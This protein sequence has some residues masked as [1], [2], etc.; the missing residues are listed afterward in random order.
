ME[1]PFSKPSTIP[2]ETDS[3]SSE[4]APVEGYL[5][6]SPLICSPSLKGLPPRFG[7]IILYGR[8][9]YGVQNSG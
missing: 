4:R 8:S 9:A 2:R 7:N 6:I 1:P 3:W 5:E